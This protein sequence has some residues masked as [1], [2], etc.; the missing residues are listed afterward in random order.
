MGRV[1]GKATN[2]V[3][4]T[5]LCAVGPLEGEA[6][7]LR[8]GRESGGAAAGLAIGVEYLVG[9]LVSG[10]SEEEWRSMPTQGMI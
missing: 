4:S 7:G 3:Y 9:P 2:W 5:G 6:A 8:S 1:L 10:P